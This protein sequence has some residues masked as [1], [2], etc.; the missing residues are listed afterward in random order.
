MYT[1]KQAAA[2]TGVAVELLRAWE[3]RY[4]IVS[5]ERTGGGYRLY[6]DA[7]LDRIRA[8]RRLVADGWAPSVAAAAVL[9]GEVPAPAVDAAPSEAAA[10]PTPA[11]AASLVET[12]VD[13]A[14]ALD[15]PSVEAALDRMFAAGSF[16]VV[17]D[18]ILLPALGALGDAWA[19]GRIG[20]AHEHAASHAILRRLAAA[21]QAAGRPSATTGAAVV[22]LP[23]G[24]RHELAALAFAV[25]ARRAGL[26]VL[27]LGPDLPVED[28]AAAVGNV[29]ARAAVIGA[30]TRADVAGASRVATAVRDADPGIVVAFGGRAAADAAE[31]DG[32]DA[33]VLPD[34]LGAAVDVLV[35]ALRNGG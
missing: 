5:P 28:W 24:C 13:A 33:V 22:G 9:R 4:G 32:P 8:M 27:Y 25:A 3:R 30:P 34:G 16:E 11:E 14:A 35:G 17:A 29:A 18:Q 7:A 21:F 23:P 26:P 1:I 19:A 31:A 20:V 6:D 15:A 12:F 2:R 10:A